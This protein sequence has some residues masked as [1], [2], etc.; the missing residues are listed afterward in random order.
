MKKIM[1]SKKQKKKIYVTRPNKFEL[2][3]LTGLQYSLNISANISSNFKNL[4]IFQQPTGWAFS[5][6]SLFLLRVL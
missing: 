3:I 6:W 1:F 4:Y 5:K 2:L